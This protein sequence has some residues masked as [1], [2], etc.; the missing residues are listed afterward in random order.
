MS[1]RYIGLMSGTSMDGI[2]AALVEFN[3][4]HIKL[5]GHHSHPISNDLRQKLL[6]LA[7]NDTTASIDMLGEVN[8]E[9]GNV[10]AD[11]TLEVLKKYSCPVS[12]IKAIGSHGQTI[13]HQ[14][15]VEHPFSMQIADANRIAYRTGIT[16]VA[17]FRGKDIA[18]G[19]QGAPLAPAFHKAVFSSNTEDRG[20]L[21]IGGIAN[22]TFLPSNSQQASFGFDTGPGN[23]LM[24]SWIKRHQ[25]KN[26]DADGNWAKSSQHDSQLLQKLL[27]DEYLGKEPPK[28]TGRERYNLQWLDTQLDE[29][30]K[31]DPAIVQATL[32][33]FT[34]QTIQQAVT[35]YM[36]SIRTLII[37]GGGNH[38]THL[39]T[40]LQN[41]LTDIR[42]CSS[43]DYGI[44]PD[45]V[46]AIAFAWLAKQTL[47]HKTVSLT[48]I[49]GAR[50]NV[51]LG[52]I[53]PV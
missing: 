30:S 20:I 19:G 53:Y 14:P 52:A 26:F 36:P 25:N 34:A 43:D 32:A 33:Q 29:F 3:N 21:N 44:E 35:K 24:D 15:D 40:L 47:E 16:T 51:I 4:Q 6:T 48:E 22:L 2:D 39:I 23:M 42:I 1:E 50:E 45:W 18:A 37:C 28:S 41:L 17:D 8:A 27:T 5:I 49:T 31:L 9:L 10:F 38:N 46:E 11:A 7:L 12:S 13:R